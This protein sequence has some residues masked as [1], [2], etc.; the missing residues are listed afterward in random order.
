MPVAVTRERTKHRRP[1]RTQESV[2]EHVAILARLVLASSF[3]CDTAA[4][5]RF[6]EWLCRIE[7]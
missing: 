1:S 3:M 6:H 2:A 5:C 4:F 7:Q